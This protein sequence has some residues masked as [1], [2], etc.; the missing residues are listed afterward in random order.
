MKIT[1]IETIP[2]TVPLDKFEDGMDKVMGQN[3]PSFYH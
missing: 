2:V 1:K 3:A